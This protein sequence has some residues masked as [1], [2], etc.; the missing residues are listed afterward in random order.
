VEADIVSFFDSL[1]RTELKKMLGRRVA[2]GS[3]MRLLLEADSSR[4]PA[5]VV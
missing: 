3:L 1:D 5:D 4:S 2:D